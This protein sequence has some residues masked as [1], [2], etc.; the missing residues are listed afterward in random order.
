MSPAVAAVQ[1]IVA[2]LSQLEFTRK[3]ARQ[4]MEAAAIAAFDDDGTHLDHEAFLETGRAFAR[5]IAIERQTRKDL[6][7]QGAHR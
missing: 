2:S 7:A 6:L 3:L 4:R 1:D 5:A